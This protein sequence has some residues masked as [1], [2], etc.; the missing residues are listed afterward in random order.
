MKKKI[1][2][3]KEVINFIFILFL[4]PLSLII[5]IL[6]YNKIYKCDLLIYQKNGGFGHTFTLQDL[7]RYVY[8]DKK[9]VYLQFYDSSR[10]N[11]YLNTIFN[12]RTITIPT[13]INFNFLKKKFGEYEGSFFSIIE[14]VI[15]FFVKNKLS[16]SQFY[17][18]LEKEYKN[19]RIKKRHNYRWTD[20]YFYLIENKRKKLNFFS[21]RLHLKNKICTIYLRQKYYKDHFSNNIRS[22][23]SDPKFYFDMINQLIKKNYIIYLIGDNVFNKENIKLFKGK[24]MDYR[25]LNLSEKYF[26]I[27]AAVNCDLFI[28]EPGGGSWFGIYAKNSILINCLPYGY[29]PINFKKI[30]YKRVI[31]SR[32]KIMSYKKANKEFYLSY[33]KIK[34]Y[35]IINNSSKELLSL[36]KSSVL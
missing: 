11:I 33:K 8:T 22:G 7:L 1:I 18:R 26:Q 13:V 28:S 34:K 27:Y 23:S 24:V 20:I 12:H 35:K 2:F 3:I 15:I 36:V 25:S 29:K 4:L 16:I 14:K 21:N 32:N 30:L 31:E 17:L 6:N 19:V 5:F 10:H 9:I